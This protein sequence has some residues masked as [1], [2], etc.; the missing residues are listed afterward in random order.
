MEPLADYPRCLALTLW[1]FP[2]EKTALLGGN[3]HFRDEIR[4]LGA[5]ST[6]EKKSM[7]LMSLAIG[8]WTTDFLHHI[9]APMVGVGIGLLA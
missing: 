4:S 9:S 2:P 3:A 8:L 5:W 1:L 7:I 6:S